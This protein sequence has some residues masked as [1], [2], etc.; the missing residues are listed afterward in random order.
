M[1]DKNSI[2]KEEDNTWYEGDIKSKQ[3]KFEH[4]HNC[5]IFTYMYKVGFYAWRLPLI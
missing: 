4:V 3:N 2:K 5:I 1:N